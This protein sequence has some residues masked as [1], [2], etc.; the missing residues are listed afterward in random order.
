MKGNGIREKLPLRNG[1]HVIFANKAADDAVQIHGA[2]GYSDEYP[3]SIFIRNSKA[4][5]IYE[6]TREIHPVMQAN[7]F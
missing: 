2:Y 3:V 1:K 7:M 4:P 5:V 6:G